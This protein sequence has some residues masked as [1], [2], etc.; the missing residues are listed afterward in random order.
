[1]PVLFPFTQRILPCQAL[2]TLPHDPATHHPALRPCACSDQ[3]ELVFQDFDLVP[4]LVQVPAAGQ[5]WGRSGWGR[6]AARVAGLVGD[7]LRAS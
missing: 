4:L 2:T 7:A 1:M 5:K 6:A 3:M